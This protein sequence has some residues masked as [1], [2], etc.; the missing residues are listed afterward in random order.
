MKSKKFV[1]AGLPLL[2]AITMVLLSAL[3][4][5]ALPLTGCKTGT[6]RSNDGST[7]DSRSAEG[8]ASPGTVVRDS[9]TI[10]GVAL[11]KT[12]EVQVLSEAVDLSSLYKEVVDSSV[13]ISGRSGT[14]NPFVMGQH[15]VTQQ[16]YLAVMENWGGAKPNDTYG[17]GDL[18]P[19]YHVSW[20]D[21]LVFCNRLSELMG[22]EPVYSKGGQ[23]DPDQ[24]G[25]VPSSKNDGWDAIT[26][27]WDANGYRL[28][29]EAEWELAARGGYHNEA[30]WND[31]YAGANDDNTLKDYAWFT[32]NS[33]R[34]THEVGTKKPNGLGLY[35]MSGNVWEW[36]WDWYG[37]ISADTPSAGGALGNIRVGRGGAWNGLAGRSAVFVRGND[38]PHRRDTNL[39]FRLVRL[40]Q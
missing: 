17:M 14:I 9:L 29:M 31:K 35:D 33:D 7:V 3:V 4:M 25:A 38:G 2:A 40:A 34:K 1:L 18:Y 13:F 8:T 10:G 28:P 20:Y 24:W 11:E 26:C 12:S 37:D 15:E 19:A 27:N 36:C 39:G 5:I 16:L 23:T 30:A 21:A 32:A 6:I 22:L